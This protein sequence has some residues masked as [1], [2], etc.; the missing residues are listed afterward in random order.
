VVVDREVESDTVAVR[1][2]SGKDLGILTLQALAKGL[3]AEIASHGQTILE[4]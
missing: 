3:S 2:R 4:T 1:T